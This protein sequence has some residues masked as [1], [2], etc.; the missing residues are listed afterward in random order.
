MNGKFSPAW[1][2]R[3]R[4]ALPPVARDEIV[5]LDHVME[6]LSSLVGRLSDV[7]GAEALGA[8]LPRGVLFH[9]E[10]GTGK[11]LVARYLASTLGAGVP[12]YELGAEELSAARLR[13][14][15]RHLAAAHARAVLF[16]DEIDQWGMSR[17]N[18]G[19]HDPETRLVLTGALSAIDGLA[20]APGVLVVAASNHGPAVLDPALV[21]PGRLGI[22]V[23]F[24][25][26]DEAER[27]SL[28]AMLLAAR[29]VEGAVDTG[30]LAALTRGATPAAIVAMVDDAAGLALARGAAAIGPGDL[31]AALRRS[32]RVD[33][34]EDL[35][36]DERRRI[37]IHESG[38]AAAAI[39]L[40]PG[41][42]TA[43]RLQAGG[44]RTELGDERRHAHL[45]PDDELR[46]L[47]VVA[48]AG[49][50]AERAVLGE[51][52][53]GGADDVASASVTAFERLTSG[54]E[55]RVPPVALDD[56]RHYL[57]GAL[58]RQA[59]EALAGDLEAARAAAAAI[60]ADRTEAIGRFAELLDAAGELVGPDLADAIRTAG[61]D[62][63]GEAASS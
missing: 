46:A 11:T 28:F 29:P 42:V 39:A 18:S 23:E 31:L 55:P 35:T 25:L 52:S 44:G 37:S 27:G 47:A 19:Y 59:L 16:L 48:M 26:P 57:P 51:P 54:I 53:R 49:I 9:G 15:M 62:W 10:P 33:P 1:L 21:R 63:P 6:E 5:G 7:A 14:T 24:D 22:H 40:R 2:E 30:R 56:L 50:A 61:L 41:W 4:V 60:V 20:P 17:E 13:G 43:V 45:V 34:N 32:G 38:H 3:H 36:P 58:K 12:M 8:P